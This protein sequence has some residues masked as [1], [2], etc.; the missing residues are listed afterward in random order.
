MTTLGSYVVFEDKKPSEW[1]Y[2]D[3]G[4][5][6]QPVCYTS[7]YPSIDDKVVW[8]PKVLTD[9]VPLYV[10]DPKTAQPTCFVMDGDKL[11]QVPFNAKTKV[12]NMVQQSRL[13]D[14]G[15]V[16]DLA[17]K[18]ASMYGIDKKYPESHPA[19]DLS[20]VPDVPEQSSTPEPDKPAAKKSIDMSEA[21]NLLQV[22]QC[23]RVLSIEDCPEVLADRE[24]YVWEDRAQWHYRTSLLGDVISGV[25]D[26]DL[27]K[28][29][30]DELKQHP[31][32]EIGE[33]PDLTLI[34]LSRP[35]LILNLDQ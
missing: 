15:I 10:Y 19:P 11:Y 35:Y 29:I 27:D 21:K 1:C 23:T 13:T 3:L 6:N 28:A 24:M 33:I 34:R 5:T 17:M 2:I 16:W 20:I 8:T 9:K 12:V 4:E 31:M 30:I 22:K 7:P 32:G 18:Q 14:Q 25:F 26:A